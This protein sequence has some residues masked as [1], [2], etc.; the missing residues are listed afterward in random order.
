MAGLTLDNIPD[1]ETRYT[2]GECIGCGVSGTVY[3]ATDADS[4]N[5][6]VAVK[7]QRLTA[8][9]EMYIQEE[10]RILKEFSDHPNL[11]D[12]YGVYKKENREGGV[13]VWFIMEV[14]IC[15]CLNQ[16]E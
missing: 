7:I 16:N 11:P 4:N 10:Y 6:K 3:V 5:K 14:S 1:P 8:D 2:L 13:D 15:K 12:F 9:T